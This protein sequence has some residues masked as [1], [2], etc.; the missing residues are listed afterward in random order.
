MLQTVFIDTFLELARNSAESTSPPSI[1]LKLRS[2]QSLAFAFKAGANVG[3]VEGWVSGKVTV[4]ETPKGAVLL[5]DTVL[6]VEGE[7]TTTRYKAVWTAETL[8][9][10]TDGALRAF[11]GDDI[12]PKTAWCELQWIDTAGTHLIAFAIKLIP[13]F[14]DVDDEAPAPNAA[15]SLAWL[16]L[17]AQVYHPQIIG[18]VG[19]GATKLDGLSTTA[20]PTRSNIKIILP[21][22]DLEQSWLLCAWIEE[23][24]DTA[25]GV[26]LPDDFD[27]ATNARFW[28]RIA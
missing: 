17:H 19:G 11:M 7:T 18:L 25:N 27:E 5:L 12:E 24:E 15:S 13:S 1:S 9:G 21:S 23:V 26:V 3:P 8:D 22:D 10:P 6:D 16:Y 28:K 20:L 4:K 2:A 14:T